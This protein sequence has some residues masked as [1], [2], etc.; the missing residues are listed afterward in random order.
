MG[1]ID[2]YI[3][4]PFNVDNVICEDDYTKRKLIKMVSFGLY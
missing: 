2:A 4:S 1:E 3:E